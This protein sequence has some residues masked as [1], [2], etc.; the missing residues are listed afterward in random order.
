MIPAPTVA[1]CHEYVRLECKA[2]E[3]EREGHDRYV[4]I[5]RQGARFLRDLSP[6]SAWPYLDLVK[7]IMEIDTATTCVTT[8][9]MRASV[10]GADQGSWIEP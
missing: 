5:F 1:L 7:K 8:I 4:P 6:P 9:L 2:R 3:M 10:F